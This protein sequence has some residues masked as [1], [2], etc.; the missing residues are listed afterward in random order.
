MLTCV[1]IENY[2]GF[3]SYRLEGL[4]RVNLLVGKN[5]SGKTAILEGI[6]FLATGGDPNVLAEAAER[7]GEVI[8]RS[9]AGR[10]PVR[11]DIARFFHGHKLVADASFSLAGNNDSAPVDVKATVRENG[12]LN[13]GVARVEPE[14]GAGLYF[15]IRGSPTET[16]TEQRE[17]PLFEMTRDGAV[18]FGFPHRLGHVAAP[19]GTHGPGSRF[20][21]PDSLEAIDMAMMWDE[22]TLTK[23]QEA[24]VEGALRI[25]ESQVESVRPL[26][27]MLGSGYAPSRA[28]FVVGMQGQEARIPLGS[29]GDGMRRIMA[30]AISLAVSQNGCLFV[31]EI[32]TGFHYSVMPD[33]WKLIVERA[34]AANAQVFATTHSWDCIEGLSL[35]CASQPSLMSEVAIHKIDRFI[36]HSI[37][38]SGDALVR[39]VKGRIDP[40]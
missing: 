18:D 38:F 22:V 36:P 27:G 15:Q 16:E 21:G 40:R 6:Q 2:R 13:S 20:I 9:L 25:L 31:D 37:E 4:S 8:V 26:T 11:V 17:Q 10:N 39:M 12:R 5:N 24:D 29:M 23:G 14:T 28:G 33:V 30:L 32:D 1:S 34:A 3:K 7:R 19:R 35:L